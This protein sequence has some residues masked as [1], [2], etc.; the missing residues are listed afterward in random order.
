MCCATPVQSRTCYLYRSYPFDLIEKIFQKIWADQI[1]LVDGDSDGDGIVPCSNSV[2]ASTGGLIAGITPSYPARPA[3]QY[4][5]WDSLLHTELSELW[6]ATLN[7]KFW[8]QDTIRPP[9]QTKYHFT[10]FFSRNSQ[11]IFIGVWILLSTEHW[12]GQADRRVGVGPWHYALVSVSHTV[13]TPPY[14]SQFI[15]SRLNLIIKTTLPPRAARIYLPRQS[16][17]Q[18]VVFL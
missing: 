12:L 1:S 3:L 4:L 5:T 9:N 16:A 15:R 14:Y 8:G 18:G 7:I 17:V 13:S 6:A 11:S 2:I 10:L